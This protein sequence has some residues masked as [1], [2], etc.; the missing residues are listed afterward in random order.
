[1]L[2]RPDQGRPDREIS[3]SFELFPPK[4][5]DQIPALD[6]AVDRLTGVGP[7]YFSVTYGA[8]G[9]TQDR[10][11]GVVERVARRTGLPVA[12][13]LTCVEAG[14]EQIDT[15]ARDLW[16]SGIRKIVAL[17]GDP[18]GGQP[19][20]PPADGYAYGAAL[21]DGLRR[22]ADFEIAVA[23]YPETHPQ[24]ESAESDLDNLK[25]KIDAG[26]T[27][28]ITQYVF[29]TDEI[30]R[31]VDRARDAGIDAPIVPG[32][33]PVS[34][35]KGLM[36]FSEKCGATVPGWL[37]EMFD[38]LD[39]DPGTRAMVAAAVAREQCRRLAEA[40]LTDFHFYTLNRAE[41]S[42]AVCRA[43][44]LSETAA[45]RRAA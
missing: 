10:T 37:V 4:S 2:K 8:G 3:V 45:P 11:R 24:A 40:G 36:R 44:G 19:Y 39:E 23:A 7:T 43:L 38:G 35:L 27:T 20:T 12:H 31:F 18:Q 5:E 16:Q 29:D 42:V 1:M 17:R 30:L 26:A 25:R 6:A 13:H 21:V 33:M 28:A 41:I 15:L 14:R 34:N 22:V 9:S 32:I